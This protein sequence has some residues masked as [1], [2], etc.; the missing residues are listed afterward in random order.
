[1]AGMRYAVYYVPE[2][3][4]ALWEFGSAWLGRDALTGENRERPVLKSIKDGRLAEITT[5]PRMYGFHATLKPPFRLTSGYDLRMLDEAVES[6]AAAAEPFKVPALELAELD[7]FIALR[8]VKSSKK[9]EAMAEDCVRAFDPFRAPPG[10]KELEKRLRADLSDKQ[11]KLLHKWGYPYV[12]SEY[13]FHMTLTERLSG[14]ER[15][16]VRKELE[17]LAKDALTG[18][19]WIFD[20]VT[21]V[22]QKGEGK[23][24]EVVKRY[25][26][27]PNVPLRWPL[28]KKK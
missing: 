3:D 7:D 4:S 1:M 26:F 20:A 23:P 17:V 21:L 25:P 27:T 5:A 16:A 18:K 11:K 14:Q 10:E 13:R 22:R 2:A 6:F 24:F 8:P 12:M 9:L 15:K 19:S 28:Q